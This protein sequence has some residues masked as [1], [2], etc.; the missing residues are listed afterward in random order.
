MYYRQNITSADSTVIDTNFVT[1]YSNG[2]LSIIDPSNVEP[3]YNQLGL[4]NGLGLRSVL[5][6]SFNAGSLPENSIIRSGNLILNADTS[7]TPAVY[8]IIIDP[9]NSDSSVVDSITIYDTDPYD[10]IGYPYR[11]STDAENWVYTFQI[12]NILQNISLG[13]ETNIGFKLVANE[14]ND[15]FESAWFSIQSE[16]RPRLEIIYVTN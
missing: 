7:L 1:I 12:K 16:S 2:D 11:V 10:A 9:L 4:S 15:P 5:N 8:N 6:I 3:S 13:N 14:K